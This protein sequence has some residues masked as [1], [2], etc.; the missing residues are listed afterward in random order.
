MYASASGHLQMRCKR[1]INK[2]LS[3]GAEKGNCRGTKGFEVAL[4]GVVGLLGT[5]FMPALVINPGPQAK[6]LKHN[7]TIC[8]AQVEKLMT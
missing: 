7:S 8:G 2:L 3:Q 5:C 6:V 1:V 4:T